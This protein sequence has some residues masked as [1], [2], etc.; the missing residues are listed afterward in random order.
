M[1]VAATSRKLLQS[2]KR[3]SSSAPLKGQKII[4]HLAKG[5]TVRHLTLPP[6]SVRGYPSFRGPTDGYQSDNNDDDLYQSDSRTRMQVSM[7]PK[8]RCYGTALEAPQYDT[9]SVSYPTAHTAIQEGSYDE[10]YDDWEM[11]APV[12]G[13]T[14]DDLGSIVFDDYDLAVDGSLLLDSMNGSTAEISNDAIM[15]ELKDYMTTV[16]ERGIGMDENDNHSSR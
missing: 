9:A 15:A 8:G 1:I 14:R 2:A 13:Q 3:P 11:H 6:G 12:A 5:V 10:D 16:Y 7:T 4:Q